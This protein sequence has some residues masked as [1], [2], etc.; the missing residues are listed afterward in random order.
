[1]P[2]M[3][4]TR[5]DLLVAGTVAGG[6]ARAGGARVGRAQATEN[7]PEDRLS[8]FRRARFGLFVHWGPYSV[9]GV[10]ASWPIMVPELAQLVGPDQRITEADYVALAD[11]FDPREFDPRS[12]VRFARDA[13][14]R[15]LVVTAKHHDGY[16]LFDAPGTEHKVTRGPYGR[17]LLAELAEACAV[18]RF[19][20]GFYYS[21][22]DMRHPGYRDTTRPATENW[23]GQPERPAWREY[24][25][26]ME[27]QLRKLLTDYGDVA[28]L[29]FDGLFEHAKY[30]P[31][32]YHR[33]V[34]EL[35]P[36]TLVN[37]RL[38]ADLGD[39]V[40]PEQAVPDGIPVRRDGPT[41]EIPVSAF[42]QFVTMLTSGL[43]AEQINQ[44]FA[45]AQRA[46]FPTERMPQPA[47]F[48]PWE[49]CMTLGAIW[50][51][52]PLDRQLK[53][54]DIVIRTLI[55]VASRG[56]N[57]LLNV[58]PTPRGTFPDSAG[59]R[60]RS[61]GA[62]LDRHGEAIYDTT[63]GPVQGAD[64]V[65]STQRGDRVF[66]HALELRDGKLRFD[67]PELEIRRAL[68]HPDGP[69]LEVTR[70]AASYAMTPPATGEPIPVIELELR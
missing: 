23:A 52:D 63:Y 69:E 62:W 35:S 53:S 15:Y 33:L 45:A 59:E 4:W 43:P 64:G 16:C 11:R 13:G 54:A 24:L 17:D 68:L 41:P 37:D 36:R 28:V 9:A 49:S 44:I 34:R 18:E 46:R 55:E 20:L 61:V 29:W 8:W 3:R 6:V 39:F 42:R 7:A 22:P 26:V 51:Y 19:P 14:M 70:E 2:S 47:R 48:Q 38:G 32:R 1:M 60:L 10:E 31:E 21:P 50:A 40:T 57:L 25:D 67:A 30:E 56:G 5:R 27:A 12:W 58:G 66:L 65:R